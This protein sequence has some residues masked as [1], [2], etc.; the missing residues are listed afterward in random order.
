MSVAGEFAPLEALIS[1]LEDMSN[2]LSIV[3]RLI[4]DGRAVDLA[5][6][7]GQIGLLCAKALDLPQ[8]QWPV[9]RPE[10]I[11]LLAQVDAVCLAM[12]S[13]DRRF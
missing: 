9:F 13:D 11:R 6:L 8:A 3:C 10:L 2:T 5:G 1:Y 4:E 7:D 12:S